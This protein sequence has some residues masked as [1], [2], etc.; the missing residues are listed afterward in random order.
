[1]TALILLNIFILLNIIFIWIKLKS[2]KKDQKLNQGLLILEGKI[3]VLEDL[4]Q[5]TETECQQLTRLLEKKSIQT[6]K[7]IEEAK[8][9]IEKI[10]KA[11]KI[12][13]EVTKIFQ[14][15]IPHKEFAERE[16]TIK[17]VKAAKKAHAGKT[18][19]A[20]EKEIDLPRSEIELIHKM[21]KNHLVFDEKTLSPWI[22]KELK[23]EK[24]SS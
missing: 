7:K 9:H 12:S 16:S 2:H 19:E 11:I 4:S 24:T 20:I 15:K 13:Q 18:I 21:N 5:R 3:K 17:Y 10:E 22:Q 23:D 14:D 1:M 6:Q 8:L